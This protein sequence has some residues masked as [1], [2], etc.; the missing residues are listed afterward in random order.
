MLTKAHLHHHKKRKSFPWLPSTQALLIKSGDGS[1]LFF[2]IL[3]SGSAPDDV[4]GVSSSVFYA[5]IKSIF[6]SPYHY[7]APF[8][9]FVSRVPPSSPPDLAYVF[10]HRMR[11]YNMGPECVQSKSST[12][13]TK[14]RGANK[15]NCHTTK[16]RL[17]QTHTHKLKEIQK[18]AAGKTLTKEK[19][20][21]R[22]R[23]T[24]IIAKPK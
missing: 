2:E 5:A 4:I 18:C 9:L 24:I 8:F 10:I 21:H 1:R 6:H 20:S 14:N 7:R 15:T 13:M 3:R 19:R 23:H 11:C 22:K 17:M 16:K 12:I